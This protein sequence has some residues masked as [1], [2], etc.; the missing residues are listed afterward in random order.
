MV[1]RM[2]R[3]LSGVTLII[4]MG[5][6]T[7]PHGLLA[8]ENSGSSQSTD[9]IKMEPDTPTVPPPTPTRLR[10]PGESAYILGA[11]DIVRVDIFETPEIT[12]DQR[13]TVLVDGTLNLPWIGNVSVQGLTLTEAAAAISARYREFVRS[14]LI[15]VSL[16]APRPLK[17]GIIGEVNRPGS[18]VMSVISGETA[19]AALVQQR[20]GGEQGNQWPTVSRALQT[21]GGI[22]QR[23][24]IRTI[25]V[26]RTLPNG[27]EEV[28]PVDLWRF[29]QEGDLSQDVLLRDGDTVAIS[30]A[31]ELDPIEATQ[32]AVSNFSPELIRVNVVGE[33]VSPGPVA[34][35]PNSTMNQAIFAAGGLRNER[36]RRKRVELVRLNPN[37]TVLRKEIDLDFSKGLD[38]ATN[39]P[40]YNN[41][42]I[43]VERSSIAKIGD[44]LST[45]LS[46]I[47]GLFGLLSILGLR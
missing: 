7:V 20:T 40:V 34:I 41:D 22:T 35:R 17:I 6:N 27:S 12:I 37:G 15:T 14:P 29:L 24:N 36:A 13:Y 45:F 31:T 4:F 26:R 8:Q 21:A 32:V 18:Y 42:V 16:L 5:M 19:T 33:V 43:I 47:T 25:Q 39:P 10:L 9:L 11:G 46:P 44:T 28:I 30:E 1:W 2:Q 23:A 3:S 38:D